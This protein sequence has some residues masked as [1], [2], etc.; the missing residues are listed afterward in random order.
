MSGPLNSAACPYYDASNTGTDIE[1]LTPTQTSASVRIGCMG[2][3]DEDSPRPPRLRPRPR[4]PAPPPRLPPPPL[5]RCSNSSSRLRLR[6]FGPCSAEFLRPPFPALTC[7]ACAYGSQQSCQ[8]LCISGSKI[9]P[10]CP[11]HSATSSKSARLRSQT[12]GESTNRPVF[13]FG[14]GPIL[15]SVAQHPQRRPH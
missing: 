8:T 13:G 10:P 7:A 9:P 2:T 1:R 3:A 14:L 5:L 15:A 4:L 12:H 11:F 6:P